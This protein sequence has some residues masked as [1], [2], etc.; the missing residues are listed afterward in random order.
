VSEWIRWLRVLIGLSIHGNLDW[1]QHTLGPHQ[2][3]AL[4]TSRFEATRNVCGRAHDAFD[5]HVAHPAAAPVHRD[6]H[7]GL[8]QHASEGRAGELATLVDVEDLGLAASGQ[9]ALERR[10]AER[11]V[12]RARE[13]PLNQ[14]QLVSAVHSRSLSHYDPSSS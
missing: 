12:Q 4:G 14:L 6:A 13:W 9:R 1:P 3:C 5:E 7:R 2:K 11:R 8:D 10:H